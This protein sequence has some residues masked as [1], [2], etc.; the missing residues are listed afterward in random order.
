[1]SNSL[2]KYSAT[3]CSRYNSSY[4]RHIPSSWWPITDIRQIH[5]MEQMYGTPM[6]NYY[7]HIVHVT[8]R[9]YRLIIILSFSTFSSIFIISIF[10][11]VIVFEVY[12]LKLTYSLCFINDAPDDKAS[13]DGCDDHPRDQATSR[14]LYDKIK[15]SISH[16]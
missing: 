10:C 1:M 12:L 14:L 4:G 7:S 9:I 6:F 2:I 11:Y 5:Q 3:S 8:M 13:D 15:K 16:L